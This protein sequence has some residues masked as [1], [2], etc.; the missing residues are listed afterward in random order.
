MTN[1]DKIRRM[2]DEELAVTIECPNETGHAEIECDHS[3]D[4]NCYE[5]CYNWLREEVATDD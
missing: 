3:D 5:C 2:S 4:C 1:G